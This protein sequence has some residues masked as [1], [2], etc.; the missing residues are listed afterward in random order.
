MDDVG[1]LSIIRYVQVSNAVLVLTG[2]LEL[3]EHL[4]LG[5]IITKRD[6]TVENMM[7]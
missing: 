7:E 2:V 6:A 5:V 4:V 3:K 1:H